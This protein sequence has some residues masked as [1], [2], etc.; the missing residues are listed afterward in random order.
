MS[1]TPKDFSRYTADGLVDGMRDDI[2][3]TPDAPVEHL[4]TPELVTGIPGGQPGTPETS[5]VPDEEPT[6]THSVHITSPHALS[7]RHFHGPT[8]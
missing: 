8:N 2:L 5:A 3:R 6:F 4:T 7:P 1:E